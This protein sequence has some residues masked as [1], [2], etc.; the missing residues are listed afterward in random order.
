MYGEPGPPIGAKFGNRARVDV[1]AR[2]R[3]CRAR[4]VPMFCKLACGVHQHVGGELARGSQ[5]EITGGGLGGEIRRRGVA[6][7]D[8]NR[9]S[10]C[11]CSPVQSRRI[12]GEWID[13]N[14]P[15]AS[16]GAVCMNEIAPPVFLTVAPSPNVILRN[17]FSVSVFPL[18]RQT[19]MSPFC[20]GLCRCCAMTTSLVVD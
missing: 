19:K 4:L 16:A 13:D 1:L 9:P 14:V 10:P 12:V 3:N 2:A 11:Q 20:L 15:G 5:R 18:M 8:C 6:R 7:T 17:A